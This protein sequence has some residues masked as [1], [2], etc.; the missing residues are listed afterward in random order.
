MAHPRPRGLRF[1]RVL[2]PVLVASVVSTAIHYTDNYL[3]IEEYPQPEWIEKSTIYSVWLMLTAV[4]AIGYWMYR[5]GW[6]VAAGACLLVYSYTGLSSLGH[7][8]FGSFSDFTAKMHFFIWT[9]GLTGAAVLACALALLLGIA[10][11]RGHR[12]EEAVGEQHVAGHEHPHVDA[13]G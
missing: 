11:A 2:A 6:R 9:D 4:G 8:F 10:P 13:A 5:T 1:D 7:Y 12:E 3:F